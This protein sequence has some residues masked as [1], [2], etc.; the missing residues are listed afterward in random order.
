LD[1]HAVLWLEDYLTKWPKTLVVVS[2]AREF[3]NTVS[4][5]Q[6]DPFLSD[7]DSEFARSSCLFAYERQKISCLL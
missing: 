5:M 3:L 4:K 2:H 1:L 7:V 6:K